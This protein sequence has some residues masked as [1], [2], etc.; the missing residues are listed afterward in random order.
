[1][2]LLMTQW[3]GKTRGKFCEI[4][5]RK[6]LNQEQIRIWLDQECEISQIQLAE[7]G[8]DTYAGWVYSL[9]SKANAEGW[10]NRIFVHFCYTNKDRKR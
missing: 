9:L 6:F 3:T 5:I 4:L 7:I 1:M 10:I 8:G 2:T